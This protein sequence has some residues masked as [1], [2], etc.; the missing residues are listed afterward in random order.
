MNIVNNE[1]PRLLRD[2]QVAAIL[3]ISRCFVWTLVKRGVLPEPTRLSS[4]HSVWKSSDVFKV[5]ENPEQ[6]V[7]QARANGRA[8]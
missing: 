1:T 5:A 6:F 8:F 7:N 2:K 3:S 4:K